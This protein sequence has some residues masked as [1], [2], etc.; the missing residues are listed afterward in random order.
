MLGQ[1]RKA[2]ERLRDGVC[3]FQD[4]FTVLNAGVPLM[5]AEAELYKRDGK[6]AEAWKVRR[7]LVEN[8]RLALAIEYGAQYGLSAEVFVKEV[9]AETEYEEEFSA[10]SPPE[11]LARVWAKATER[12]DGILAQDPATA[13]V[14]AQGANL[15]DRNYVTA[16]TSLD[17]RKYETAFQYAN[18]CLAQNPKHLWAL[19]VMQEAVRSATAEADI[20]Q[21]K[22]VAYRLVRKRDLS[23]PGAKRLEYDIQEVAKGM[24]KEE[25]IA[26]ARSALQ[27][28]WKREKADAVRIY[29]TPQGSL[30]PYLRLT[31]APGGDWEKAKEGTPYTEFEENLKVLE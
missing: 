10:S 1:W 14:P 20:S 5:A 8:R 31:W 22:A 3:T 2:C 23:L 25:A 27:G 26:T 19:K 16:K 21:P 12:L 6:P 17:N 9:L 28:F 4:A 29:L 24:T 15:T 7:A 11:V 18:A 13:T 30:L